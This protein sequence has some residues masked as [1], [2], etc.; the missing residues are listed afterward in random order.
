MKIAG[1]GAARRRS[2]TTTGTGGRRETAPCHAGTHVVLLALAI[3][4]HDAASGSRSS[5]D[6]ANIERIARS[7]NEMAIHICGE[8]AGALLRVR[9]PAG[10]FIS[11]EFSLLPL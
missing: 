3:D 6:A 8:R 10:G 9:A 4:S 2:A 1:V 5:F 11:R 7:V